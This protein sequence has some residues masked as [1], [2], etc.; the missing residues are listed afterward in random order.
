MK[1]IIVRHG[2]TDRNIND[3]LEGHNDVPLNVTGKSQVDLLAKRLSTEHIDRI[4]SSDLVRAKETAK[5]I[6]TF[7]PSAPVVIDKELRERDSGMFAHRPVA[8]KR[9]AQ[10]ASGQH[11]RDWQ[12]EGGESLRQVKERSGRWYVTHRVSDAG[13]TILIVSHGLFLS[14]LMEWALEDGADVE[15]EEYRHENAAITILDIPLTGSVTPLVINNTQ[16]LKGL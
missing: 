1:L 9:A 7:H 14:T 8:D 12:P 11:F 13:K 4:Y 2:E 3:F 16:H 5:T 10:Q 15:K 6:A